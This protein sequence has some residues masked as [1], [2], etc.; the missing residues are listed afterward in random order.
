MKNY[1]LTLTLLAAF[2]VSHAQ[3]AVHLRFDHTA[4]LVKDLDK[5]ARFYRE[6]LGL[7]EIKNRTEQATIKWFS[8]GDQMELHLIEDKNATSPEMKGIHMAFHS[9]NLEELMQHLIKNDIPFENWM[10]EAQKTNLRADGIRQIYLQ[11]PDNYWIEIN[12]K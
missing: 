5:S 8:M 12:G 10:G 2:T 1:I 4:I 11:D 6:V 3:Q 9:G 7:E